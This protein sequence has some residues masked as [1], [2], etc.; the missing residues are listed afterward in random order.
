MSKKKQLV[1]VTLNSTSLKKPPKREECKSYLGGH[2]V[3]VFTHGFVALIV[4]DVLEAE[5]IRNQRLHYGVGL[6]VHI[7]IFLKK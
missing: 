1:N 7:I 6:E 2:I 4:T 5:S 3:P